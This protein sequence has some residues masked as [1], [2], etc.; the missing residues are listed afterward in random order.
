MR[1]SLRTRRRGPAALAVP[2]VTVALAV[3]SLTSCGLARGERYEDDSALSG[4]DRITSVRLENGAG[5]VTVNGVEDGTGEHKLHRTF[6]YQG[7]RPTGATHRIEDGVLVLGGCGDRCAVGYTVDLPAGLPV[8]GEVSSGAVRLSRVGAV[9]V[10]TGSGHVELEGVT[11]SVQ[12]RTTNGPISGTGIQADRIQARTSNGPIDLTP[13]APA[14][15]RAETA[16]GPVTLTVPRAGY[17]VTTDSAN[18]HRT[19]DV[20]DDPKGAYALDVRTGNGA[21][22]VRNG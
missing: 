9:E 12:V 14:D 20:P 7:E 16:N 15:I 17:R 10:T 21:I 2:A 5:G 8:S 6:D 13:A 19:V 18:G 11:G 22:T 1:Q 4:A 3:G